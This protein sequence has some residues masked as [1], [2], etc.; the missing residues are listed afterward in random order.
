MNDFVEECRREW[1]R[2]RVPRHIA[3]EMAAELEADLDEAAP[4]DVLGSDAFDARTFAAR[5]AAERGVTRRRLAT[6][7]LLVVAAILA[8]VAVAGAGGALAITAHDQVP[9]A[10]PLATPSSTEGASVWVT[11]PNAARVVIGP[12]ML[13]EAS[14]TRR[15]IGS[16]LLIA[17][18]ACVVLVTLVPGTLKAPGTS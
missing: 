18:L 17:G 6:R 3:D 5:W 13:E 16:A 8:S 11:S 7:K 4:E 2:L 14:D 10:L 1:R 9:T 12:R 15:T